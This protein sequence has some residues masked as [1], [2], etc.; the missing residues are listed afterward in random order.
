M[1]PLSK[2]C[3]GKREIEKVIKVLKSGWLTSGPV[4]QEFEDN[5]SDYC[6]VKY[7]SAVSSGT[8]ALDLALKSIGVSRGDEVIIPSLTFVATA[9]AVLMQGAKPVFVDIDKTTYNMA[10]ELIEEKVTKKTK[11]IIPVHYAGQSCLMDEINKVAKTYNLKVIEDACHAHG[12]IYSNGKIVGDSNNLVCFSFHPMKNM[13][14]GEG[15]IVTSNNK[16]LMQKIKRMRNHGAEVS[17]IKRFKNKYISR[18]FVS[19]GTN[20]RMSDIHAAIAVEQLEKLDV[21]NNKR[22]QIANYYYDMLKNIKQITLPNLNDDCVYHLFTIQVDGS[23]S[24]FMN[25]MHENGISTGIYY[26][27]VHLEP[28]MNALGYGRESLPVTEEVCR[29][30]ISL[31]MYPDLKI[32]DL[33]HIV[34]T[35]KNYF[36]KGDK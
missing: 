28:Y 29:H 5:F 1:I 35:I 22:K 20:Y 18:K 11:A 12:A 3:I 33:E 34:N 9:N 6:N 27:P 17:A 36:K 31:P 24:Q 15:G 30:I 21:N 7:A 10:H 8:A 14:S 19:L 25:Y 2:P 23:K 26:N 16:K 32:K 13:T 4:V